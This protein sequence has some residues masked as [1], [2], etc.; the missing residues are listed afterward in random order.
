MVVPPN[1]C[2]IVTG[3]APSS[4]A[5]ADELFSWASDDDC[6]Q[7]VRGSAAATISATTIRLFRWGRIL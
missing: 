2:S 1:A 5:D 6:V 3:Y 4:T 7:A